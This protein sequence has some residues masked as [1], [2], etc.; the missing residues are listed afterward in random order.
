[1]C[2]GGS[3]HRLGVE[4]RRAVVGELTAAGMST[5]TI[6]PVVGVGKST[7]DRR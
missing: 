4:V 7:G 3:L 6:A 2:L 1:L 5:R